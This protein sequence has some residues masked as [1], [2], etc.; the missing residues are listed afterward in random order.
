VLDP[1]AIIREE[2]GQTLGTFWDRALFVLGLESCLGGPDEE[3]RI[4]GAPSA[5]ETLFVPFAPKLGGLAFY[6]SYL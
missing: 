2:L 3:D 4:R 1:E 5:P 6:L